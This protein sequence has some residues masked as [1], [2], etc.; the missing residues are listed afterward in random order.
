MGKKAKKGNG[1]FDGDGYNKKVAGQ[2]TNGTGKFKK[3][4]KHQSNSDSQTSL[5]RYHYFVDSSWYE[6]ILSYVGSVLTDLINLL[7]NRLSLKQQNTSRRL[8]IFSK[9]KGWMWRNDQ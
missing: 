4:S 3:S 1:G 9:A 6:K 2:V 7:G 5:I 8:R